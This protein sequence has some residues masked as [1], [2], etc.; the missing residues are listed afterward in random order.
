M[1]CF[2]RRSIVQSEA[3]WSASTTA[4]GDI[5]RLMHSTSTGSAAIVVCSLL[6]RAISGRHA[7]RQF[8]LENLLASYGRS[9]FSVLLVLSYLSGE[10]LKSE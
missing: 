6:L 8:R 4:S 7:L 2:E 10:R 1:M 9:W 3:A 5:R